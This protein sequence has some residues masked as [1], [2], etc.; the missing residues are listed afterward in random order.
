MQSYTEGQLIEQP[1]VELFD[2]LGWEVDSALD[3]VAGEQGTLGRETKAEVVLLARLRP[4]LERLN[5]HLPSEAISAAID[6]L[7]R[8][9]SA[10]AWPRRIVMFMRCSKKA[11]SSACPIASAADRKA[12]EFA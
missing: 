1:A 7:T 2:E 5:P 3:E 4:A 12:S 9:R 10:M 6:E 8:D 11:C